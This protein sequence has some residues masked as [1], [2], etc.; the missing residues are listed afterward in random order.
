MTNENMSEE[1][2]IDT[3]V[4]QVRITAPGGRARTIFVPGD[5]PV[6]E[7]ERKARRVAHEVLDYRV[8]DIGMI[9]GYGLCHD[10]LTE[11][12]NPSWEPRG[13]LRRKA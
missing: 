6:S 1:K 2:R 11:K 3:D 5:A 7:V 12:R 8:F 10:G 9:N 13:P 4:A